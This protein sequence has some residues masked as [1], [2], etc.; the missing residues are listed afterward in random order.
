MIIIIFQ[1]ISLNEIDLFVIWIFIF[2][3]YVLF[4]IRL[5]SKLDIEE[6]S[7]LFNAKRF[8]VKYHLFR[9]NSFRATVNYYFKKELDPKGSFYEYRVKIEDFPAVGAALLKSKK[10]EWIIFAISSYTEIIGFFINKGQNAR[11]VNTVYTNSQILKKVNELEGKL[12]IEIHNHPNGVLNPSDQDLKSS[13]SYGRLFN[14]NNL[15]YIAIVCSR[16]RFLEYAWWYFSDDTE[17]EELLI[18]IENKSSKNRFYN[19]L[20]RLE[21]NNYLKQLKR[22]KKKGFSCS[23]LDNQ[24]NL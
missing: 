15:H 16:G 24:S 1:R 2:F 12:I 3:I 20:L 9:F 8:F 5:S 10:H 4:I 23:L 19:L 13:I 18:E 14:E 6:K 22:I 17:K 7:K 11:S 21:L